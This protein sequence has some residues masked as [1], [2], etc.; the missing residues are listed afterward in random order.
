MAGLGPSDLLAGVRDQDRD[1]PA[2]VDYWTLAEDYGIDD[3]AVVDAALNLLRV[4]PN[5]EGLDCELRYQAEDDARPVVVHV[6]DEPGRVAEELEEAKDGRDPPAGIMERLGKTK[7]IV[8]I[9]LGFSQ[10]EDMGVV[11]A[12]EVARWLAQRGD[13][14]IVDDDNAW[15]SVRD[16]GWV[17]LS[18]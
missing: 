10:L 6:W 8:G 9:E 14:L 16:G 17:G 4:Q 3:T 11:L 2:G 1:A 5:G 12:Y 15:Q 18:A 13:G 7:V